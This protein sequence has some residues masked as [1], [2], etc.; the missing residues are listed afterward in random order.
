[1]GLRIAVTNPRLPLLLCALALC[2][3]TD[4]AASPKETHKLG[5]EAIKSGR[6]ADA[7][8][9]FRAAIAERPQEKVSRVLKTAY[10][11]H[12]YLGVALA[13]QGN[14]KTA[15]GAW[16]ESTRQGQILKSDHGADLGRRRGA[17]QDRLR[18]IDAA[19]AEVRELLGRAGDAAASLGSLSKTP[20]LAPLWNQGT[21]SFGA[22][23]QSAGKKLAD[24]QKHFDDPSPGRELEQL[25]R[26]KTLASSA[27][28]ELNAAL[29][30]GRRRLGELNAAT[31]VALE[32]LEEV[33][34]SARRTL[35]S[36]SDLA[37]YPRRLG[38]RVA[39][40]ERKLKEIRESKSESSPQRFA[41]L[42]GEL[43]DA[44]AA[45]RRA[46]RRPSKALS[47]AVEAFL[48]GSYADA[49][50]LLDAPD[51]AGDARAQP[52]VC[53]IR[54]ASHHALWVLG[55]ELDEALRELAA[56][57]VLA[58]A[59]EE[60]AESN[61]SASLPPSTRIYSPR[62]VDFHGA[63]LEA[64]AQSAELEASGLETGDAGEGAAGA[65]TTSAAPPAESDT[66]ATAGGQA[67][68]DPT[69][70]GG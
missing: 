30:D 38:S 63:A 21:T 49:L 47:Q 41:E 50:A 28:A 36:I 11:P 40:V 62:F 39:A 23:Q 7:E 51:L 13:E 56:E 54:A 55:G 66:P 27:L 6:W 18:R 14:C 59:G 4:A 46:A 15:L 60:S 68:D 16:A 26:A 3:A 67:A 58:C 1:M 57:A 52:H 19:R 25:D 12:Y 70:T 43:N 31:A 65:A 5:V 53:M 61:A 17:C 10:L 37:P 44:L 8:R 42:T 45:L 34:Q 32:Q 64:R 48:T 24:A 20:D 22:R 29:T 2:I 9:F 33:E 69:G 35:R